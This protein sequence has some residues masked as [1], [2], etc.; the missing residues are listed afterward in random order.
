MVD[1]IRKTGD[2]AETVPAVDP[3][4]RFRT[5]T[6]A[7]IGLGR[8]GDNLLTRDLLAFQL[9]HARARDAVS[10]AVDFDALALELAPIASVRVKS[11]AI[12]RSLYLRRPDLGRRLDPAFRARLQKDDDDVVFVIADGLSAAAVLAHSVATLKACMARL[13]DLRVGPVVFVEQGRVAIGDEIGALMGARMVVV[14][15]GERPGLSSPDSLGAYITFA[16]R[17]GRRDADRNCVSNVHAD[18]LTAVAAA[19]KITWIIREGLRLQLTGVGLKEDADAL[20]T[21]PL[22]GA[23]SFLT[24]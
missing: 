5:L 7:R 18:G 15:I 10:G 1:A 6:R 14:L 4:T 2:D 20:V 24:D 22:W 17:V 8:A 23:N 3:W 19:A 11:A 21:S 9:A 16:P 13:T 12:D